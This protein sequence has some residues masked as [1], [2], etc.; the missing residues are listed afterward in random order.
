MTHEESRVKVV[1]VFVFCVF[2]FTL[3]MLTNAHTVRGKSTLK[4]VERFRKYGLFR[5]HMK[6]MKDLNAMKAKVKLILDQHVM[7]A[8]KAMKANAKVGAKVINNAKVINYDQ[9]VMH[10]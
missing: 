2:L 5:E 10:E 8:L 1:K 4:D 6:A 7:K 3:E 9:Y